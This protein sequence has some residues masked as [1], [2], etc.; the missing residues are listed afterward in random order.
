M[1]FNEIYILNLQSYSSSINFIGDKVPLIKFIE[2]GFFNKSF[3]NAI[4]GVKHVN[5]KVILLGLLV[6]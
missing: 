3:L 4:F 2:F 6:L 5:S 1:W